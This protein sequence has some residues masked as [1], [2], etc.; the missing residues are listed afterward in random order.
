MAALSLAATVAVHAAEADDRAWGPALVGLVVLAGAILLRF[1]FAIPAAVALLGGAYL[2]G[3]TLAAAPLDR[4]APLVAAALLAVSELAHW[5]LE[6]RPGVET[7]A[8]VTRSRVRALVLTVAAAG[9]LA[10]GAQVVATRA[11]LPVEGAAL[12]AV[13]LVA[14]FAAVGLLAYAATLWNRGRPDSDAHPS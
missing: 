11:V 12:V 13:G 10:F 1:R 8:D 4:L 2:M 5:S 7:S 3:L 9:G 6:S 14:G